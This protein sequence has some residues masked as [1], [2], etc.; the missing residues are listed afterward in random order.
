MNN[1][2]TSTE[3]LNQLSTAGYK[4]SG[5]DG[6]SFFRS[7]E[8]ITLDVVKRVYGANTEF[9]NNVSRIKKHSIAN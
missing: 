6:E 8:G 2:K 3:R 9:L 1:D 5:I 7:F 4:T